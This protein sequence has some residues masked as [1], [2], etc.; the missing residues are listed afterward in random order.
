[1]LVLGSCSVS[2]CVVGM[3]VGM[4]RQTLRSLGWA[5]ATVTASSSSL[6]SLPSSEWRVLPSTPLPESSWKVMGGEL[7]P[8]PITY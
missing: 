1:M 5:V 8:A 7:V 4:P 3:G 2:L 6:C